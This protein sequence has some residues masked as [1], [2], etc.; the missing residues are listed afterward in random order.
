V[1]TFKG[2]TTFGKAIRVKNQNMNV[3][4]GWKFIFVF[5]LMG[6]THDQLLLLLDEWNSTQ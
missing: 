2:L 3:E 4:D 5:C 1:L 6:I